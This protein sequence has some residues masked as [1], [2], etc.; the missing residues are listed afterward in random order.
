MKLSIFLISL[1]LCAFVAN[2]G[3]S[4]EILVKA[5][6]N[7]TSTD[8]Y[9]RGMPVSVMPDDTTWGKA[10]TWPDFVKIKVP[11]IAV[12]KCEKYIQEWRTG[13]ALTNRRIWQIRWAD[14]P[15]TAQNLFRDNGQLVIQATAAYTGPYDYTWDA[16]KIYFRNLLTGLDET[17]AL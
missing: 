7:C 15:L 10:E 11:L 16:V 9:Q 14:L 17:E 6:P 8:C 5:V 1:C 2:T 13:D 4:C 3:F 12:T